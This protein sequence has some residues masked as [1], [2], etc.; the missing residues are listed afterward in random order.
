MNNYKVDYHIHT[1]ASD[2]KSSPTDVVKMAK[3]LEYDIIAITDHDNMEGI[4]EALIAGKALDMK[5]VPGIE[6]AVETEDGIGLHML[7]YNVNHEDSRFKEFLRKL[8]ENRQLRNEELFK[9]LKD[10]GYE[11]NIDEI[12]VGKNN[13]IGKP[14]IA[15]ELLRKGYIKSE[16]EAYGKDILGSEACRKVKKVKP[17]AK[18]AIDE[19]IK[20]GGTPVLAHPIQTRGIGRPGSELFFENIEKIIAKLK[21]QG[22]KGLE[23]YHP[24]Q[25]D[26]ESRRFIELAEK[27]K[28]HVTQGSDF[29]GDDFAKADK[30]ANNKG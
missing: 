15:R 9:T 14:I 11:I 8:I 25:N 21:K 17:L 29:H 27:Y 1:T 4:P 6:I 19:I 5:V 22:L 2:G 12:Q 23:C 7:G 30:H 13:F 20:A 10:L 3:E 18:D 26:E 24:D 28:L 16:G